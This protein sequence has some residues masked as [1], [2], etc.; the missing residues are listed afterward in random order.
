MR[1]PILN[2]TAIEP[3]DVLVAGGG[4]AGI[5]AAIAAARSGAKTMLID[6]AGWLGG[7]GATGAWFV[8]TG[9]LVLLSI[10]TGLRVRSGRWLEVG[11]AMVEEEELR[12]AA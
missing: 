2:T 12:R 5:A 11:A 8:L 6:K 4:M 9:E 7:M 10:V 1:T 3:V